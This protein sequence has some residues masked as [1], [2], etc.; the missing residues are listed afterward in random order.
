MV[1]VGLFREKSS[2]NPDTVFNR[3]FVLTSVR[4]GKE[5]ISFERLAYLSVQTESLIVI[6]SDGFR[7]I[8]IFLNRLYDSLLN[9]AGMFATK[10]LQPCLKVS[11]DLTQPVKRFYG[12][13][14]S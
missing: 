14:Q 10:L 6:K 1:K 8:W 12:P 2:D 7:R 13:C 3:S 11:F 5:C 4:S 9:K